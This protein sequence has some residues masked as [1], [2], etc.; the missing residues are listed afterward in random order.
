[1]KRIKLGDREIDIQGSPL[2]P[3]YYKR[4]FKQ[5]FSGDLLEMQLLTGDVTQFDDVN[6]LQMIWAMEKT[7]RGGNLVDFLTWLS[8]FE[9]IDLAGIATK[10]TGEA[11]N[12]TFREAPEAEEKPKPKPKQKK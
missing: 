6:L 8:E 4:E 10:V 11:M 5:S 1:M 7:A 3:L 9:W 12:A 2:T